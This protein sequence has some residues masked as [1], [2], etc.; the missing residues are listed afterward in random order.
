MVLLHF[1]ATWCGRVYLLKCL[2]PVE[3]YRF[4]GSNQIHTNSNPHEVTS[5]LELCLALQLQ[6]QAEGLQNEKV[7]ACETLALLRG[8]SQ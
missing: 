4:P 8:L 1:Y 5:C 2:H 7:G 3:I 6:V